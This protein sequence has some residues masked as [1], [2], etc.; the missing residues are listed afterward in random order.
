VSADGP[1]PDL[2]RLAAEHLAT[3]LESVPVGGPLRTEAEG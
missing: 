2:S 3:L 1:P